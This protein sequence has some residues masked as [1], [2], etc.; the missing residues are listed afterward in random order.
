MWITLPRGETSKGGVWNFSA[1]QILKNVTVRAYE[2]YRTAGCARGPWDRIS[3]GNLRTRDESE[4]QRRP[5]R[6]FGIRSDSRGALSE[7]RESTFGPTD[8]PQLRAQVI[9]IA[10]KNNFSIDV[11]ALINC[12]VGRLAD[13]PLREEFRLELH[14][15]AVD[16]GYTAIKQFANDQLEKRNGP[17]PA[18]QHSL[19]Y[20]RFSHH[21]DA[22]GMRYLI[23]SL[24]D[25]T[26]TAIEAKLVDKAKTR[27][28]DTIS[29]QQALADALSDALLGDFPVSQS[30]RPL[31][32]G[33]IMIPADGWRHVG[34]QWLVSTDGAKIHA[35]ELADHLLADFGYAIVYDEMAEPVDL[36]R[37][38]RFANDKQRLIL[39]ADQLLCADPQCTRAAYRGQ[40]HHIEAWKNGG[41]TNLKN[42]CLTC[43]PHNALND[44]DHAK[45]KH[46]NGH[47][48]RDKYNGRIGWQPPD[49]TKSIRFNNHVLA[50]KSARSWAIRHFGL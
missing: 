17:N 42:L 13:A 3:E 20:A 44:D 28:S 39:T 16:N 24:P 45:G 23:T 1:E 18:R 15:F 37:T 11:L 43:G 27:K 2:H 41:D 7:N 34:D 30:S 31:R 46:K 49:P 36:Y 5:C 47:Y 21:P 32:E 48:V 35:S 4:I 25:E 29:M 26:M 10:Q 50:Q 12:K 38:Q 14:R 19:R 6:Y 22:N 9:A 33:L 40:A 8:Q